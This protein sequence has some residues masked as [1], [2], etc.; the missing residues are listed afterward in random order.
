MRTL[1]CVASTLL[2]ISGCGGGGGDDPTPQPTTGGGGGDS[3]GST[4]TNAAPAGVGSDIITAEDTAVTVDLDLSDA[5]GDALT[6]SIEQDTT[7]GVVQIDGSGSDF[8]ATYTPG[9]DFFG[10]DSFVFAASDGTD[11]TGDLTVNITVTAVNDPPQTH[12]DSAQTDEDTALSGSL[13]ATDV[14]GDTLEFAASAN[15]LNGTV[16]VNADGRYTYTPAANFNGAD[17]FGFQ[18]ADGTDVAT[19]SISITVNPIN[20]GP[21][22]VNDEVATNEDVPVSGNVLSNDSDPEGDTLTATRAA[23]PVNGVL[24]LLDDGSFT[25]MPN[26]NFVGS[27]NFQYTTS[28]GQI[29]TAPATVIISVAGVNDAPQALDDAVATNEDEPIS[30]NVLSNDFDPDGDALT[31]TRASDPMHGIL[32]LQED[33]SFTYTP[34]ADFSGADSFQYTTSD[35][36]ASTLPATVTISVASVNDAPLITS[37]PD[38]LTVAAGSQFEY[39]VTTSDQEGDDVT[40]AFQV[41]PADPDGQAGWLGFS[42][43]TRLLIGIPAEFDA[44]DYNIVITA[45]DGVESTEQAFVITVTNEPPTIT[46][47]APA[48]AMQGALYRYDMEATDPNPNGTTVSLQLTFSAPTLPA[49]LTLSEIAV[50][51][52]TAALTGTPGNGDV[53][54]HAVTVRATDAGGMFAEQS[55]SIEVAPAL[56][57]QI[58]STPV[59]E[60][61]I[62]LVYVYTVTA[63]D[64]QND[65]ITLTKDLGGQ[66][67]STPWL[68]LTPAGSN[69]WLLTGMP[70]GEDFGVAQVNLRATD[71]TGESSVQSYSLSVQAP[72]GSTLD[73][74][75]AAVFSANEDQAYMYQVTA[76]HSAGIPALISANVLPDWLDLMD[77]GGGNALLS[78]V[79]LAQD[80]GDHPVELMVDAG[81]LQAL[82]QFT[83]TVSAVNDAPVFTSTAPPIALIGQVYVYTVLVEDEDHAPAEL[84]ISSA[85]ALP[86]WLGLLPQ[87]NGGALL[88]GEPI[89][90][91]AGQV[92][93]ELVV[94]D[95]DGASSTQSFT[96]SVQ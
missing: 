94:T 50:D 24:E 79:A 21:L 16:T 72:A 62:D 7:N 68:G 31:A 78:G 5:D 53:G 19:A 34:D 88:T 44:G 49:W 36:L 73:F 76:Q 77:M 33:G 18:V 45:S 29:T 38:E 23:D 3:G 1:A 58:T 92:Q 90:D 66:P 41:T 59:T 51:Q 28:D 83:I 6:V 89:V 22:A 81:G 20:D 35:G 2:F 40:I 96:I 30:G 54:T 12:N 14:D 82:Q 85:N 86:G 91:D 87:G 60:A 63:T 67:D 4:M 48:D 9:Q 42:N 39:A 26:A 27:D 74:T 10:N 25:Y 80:V 46:S 13:D 70:I 69:T 11:S 64:A 93:I 61:V 57:P 8:T 17:S 84:T 43:A 95:G 56:A 71:S 52:G 15:P 32:D 75:S 55:F 37:T 47:T 65:A